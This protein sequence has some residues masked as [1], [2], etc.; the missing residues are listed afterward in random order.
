MKLAKSQYQETALQL[1][2]QF[3]SALAVLTSAVRIASNTTIELDAAQASQRQ[4][5]ARYRPGL[6][7]A[8]DV[9]PADQFLTQAEIDH[10]VANVNV[11]QAF[12][13]VWRAAGDLDPFLSACR[14]AEQASR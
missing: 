14:R 8:L 3:D 1:R 9:E 13:L 7:T 4:N 5:L 11:W 10:S 6:A 12:L 2:T